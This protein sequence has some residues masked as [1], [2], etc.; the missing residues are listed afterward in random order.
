M[1]VTMPS[2]L[3]LRVLH[4]PLFCPSVFQRRRG[5]HQDRK[6]RGILIL[7][8]FTLNK[9]GLPA[10]GGLMVRW[11]VLTYQ[12]GDGLPSDGILIREPAEHEGATLCHL[13][14]SPARYNVQSLVSKITVKARAA[15]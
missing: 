7:L 3:L 1:H 15:A 9:D 11:V 14:T 4:A 5:T 2:I 12:W 6:L 13:S 8:F 10:D